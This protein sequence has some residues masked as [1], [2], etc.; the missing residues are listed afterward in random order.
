V[1]PGDWVVLSGSVPAGAAAGVYAQLG[2]RFSRTG[3]SVAVDTS[4]PALVEAVSARPALVKP[5]R[6]ELGEALG[7]EVLSVADAVAAAESLRRAGAGMVLAS[8]GADG[9][10]LVAGGGTSWGHCPVEAR[11]SSVGAGDSLL[12]GFLSALLAGRAP[13][14]ALA[15]A[16][17]WAA[18]AVELPGS[19]VPGP[20]D[21]AGRRAL[22]TADLDGD[23]ALTPT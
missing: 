13:A 20:A 23:R 22:V 21:I 15:T 18:A 17:C 6:E 4:G 19:R 10:V 9:A 3:A 2:E 11:R 12:A 1:G 16:V 14:D 5:N 8:L 7:R